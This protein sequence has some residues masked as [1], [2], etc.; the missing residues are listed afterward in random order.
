MEKNL[1]N[2]EVDGRASDDEDSGVMPELCITSSM[3]EAEICARLEKVRS[4][5]N[6]ERLGSTAKPS[7]NFRKWCICSL[8]SRGE[9][10][11]ATGNSARHHL[12]C[13]RDSEPTSCLRWPMFVLNASRSGCISVRPTRVLQSKRGGSSAPP[14]YLG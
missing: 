3:T 9:L 5:S 4:Y 10:R 12:E 8:K 13:L 14:E 1:A 11:G 6:V 7:T 2:L